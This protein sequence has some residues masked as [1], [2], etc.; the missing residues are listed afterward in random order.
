M[1]KFKKLIDV[2]D[3]IDNTEYG[4][5]ISDIDHEGTIE[6]PIPFPHIN[7]SKAVHE[8]VDA[9]YDFHENNPEYGLDHY[10]R[11]MEENGVRD[12]ASSDIES[13]DLQVVMALLMWVVRGER[14]CDGHILANLKEGNIQR[15]LRRLSELSKNG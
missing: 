5:C 12:I 14:F 15:L 9:V 8:F 7:Y 1:D 4:K 11:I 13:L 3:S 6:D 10:G 2:L